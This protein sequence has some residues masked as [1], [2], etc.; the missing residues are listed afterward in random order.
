[1]RRYRWFRLSL[2]GKSIKGVASNME[3]LAFGA[4]S[5]GGFL[6]DHIRGG[7]VRGRYVEKRLFKEVV[8]NP[9]GGEVEYERI[10][11]D[12]SGFILSSSGP[13]LLLIDPARSLSHLLT[14]LAKAA[15]FDASISDLDV[16]LSAWIN[17]IVTSSDF[18][19][20]SLVCSSISLRSG[21]LAKMHVVGERDV[22][23]DMEKLLAG[24]KA[25]IEKASL[26]FESEQDIQ[27]EMRRTATVKFSES[28]ERMLL[29]VFQDSLS[30]CLDL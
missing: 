22:R 18:L 10:Q 13:G 24:R 17:C 7:T 28:Y 8:Q 6:V 14:N 9:L 3:R 2:G 25:T 19:V 21:A 16:D 30:R 4:K 27:V 11:Y 15:D 23:A 12:V 29:P 5:V 1:M 26:R 20:S